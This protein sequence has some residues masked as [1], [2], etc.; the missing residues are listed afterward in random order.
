MD[1]G[2]DAK[3]LI[4][5]RHFAIKCLWISKKQIV[6]SPHKKGQKTGAKQWTTT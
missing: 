3:K 4:K 6:L 5:A 1:M 2:H